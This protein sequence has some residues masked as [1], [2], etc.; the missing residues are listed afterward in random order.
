MYNTLERP[1]ELNTMPWY[2]YREIKSTR[3]AESYLQVLYETIQASLHTR[4][5]MY[6]LLL[7]VP[8]DCC[9]SIKKRA[10]AAKH[11]INCFNWWPS[12]YYIELIKIT[13]TSTLRRRQATQNHSQYLSSLMHL[14]LG[15]DANI[16]DACIPYSLI[17]YL[18]SASSRLSPLVQSISAYTKGSMSRKDV[19]KLLLNCKNFRTRWLVSVKWEMITLSTEHTNI[20][21]YWIA[22]EDAFVN[23]SLFKTCLESN[24][25]NDVELKIR[26]IYRE[27]SDLWALIRH[28]HVSKA[29]RTTFYNPSFRTQRTNGHIASG[30]KHYGTDMLYS[31]HMQQPLIHT[32]ISSSQTTIYQSQNDQRSI[33]SPMSLEQFA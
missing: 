5:A 30:S 15:T 26:K 3:I 29:R 12:F 13:T 17:F 9:L 25:K 1:N 18:H 4:L 19:W 14:R 31:T 33:A 11:R 20:W 16:W 24:N 22:V 7:V 28:L 27:N 23:Y 21:K 32:L 10:V 6:T 8:M 2:V